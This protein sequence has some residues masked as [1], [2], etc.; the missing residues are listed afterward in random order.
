MVTIAKNDN[1]AP[2]HSTTRSRVTVARHLDRIRLL[3]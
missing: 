3:S 1:T 2:V